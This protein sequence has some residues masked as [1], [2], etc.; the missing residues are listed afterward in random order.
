MTLEEWKADVIDYTSD[1]IDQ[2]QALI[3]DVRDCATL[4]DAKRVFDEWSDLHDC[5]TDI[6]EVKA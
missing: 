3:N 1:T 4:D 6:A 2:R 5:F